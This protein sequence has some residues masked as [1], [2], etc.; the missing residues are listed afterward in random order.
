MSDCLRPQNFS[1]FK[2]NNE[3]VSNLKAYIC[4]AR[5]RN[6]PLDHCLIYGLPGTGKTTL[7]SIIANEMNTKIKILQGTM[8]NKN[9]D[10]INVLLSISEG[11]VIFIDE[12]HCINPQILELLFTAMED[13]YFDITIGKDFNSKVTRL[14]LPYFTL[15]G[16]TTKFGKIPLPLEERFGI[17][18]NIREYKIETIEE[19]IKQNCTKMNFELSNKEI[20]L[21][22]LKCKCIPRNAINILKRVRDFRYSDKNISMKEIFKKLKIYDNGLND[23]D[24]LFLNV[25][26]KSNQPIGLKTLSDI[27]NIDQETIQNKIEPFLLNNSLIQKNS[28]GRILTTKGYDLLID[29][30]NRCR[31]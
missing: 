19:I 26:K 25:L 3:T 24:L 30:E 11:D 16:A 17:I 10:I 29:I 4:S 20:N 9:I 31:D 14:K 18:I 12:I 5:K 1:E 2:G 22:A 15:I 8:L 21:I 23:N 28:K 7:A 13:F 6:M 27:V